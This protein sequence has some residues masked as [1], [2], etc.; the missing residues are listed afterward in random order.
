MRMVNLS[1]KRTPRTRETS[2]K[3]P[4]TPKTLYVYELVFNTVSY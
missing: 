4:K 1:G 3:P 2:L